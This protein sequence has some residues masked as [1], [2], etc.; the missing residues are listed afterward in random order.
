MG[1][2]WEFEAN[3]GECWRADFFL[4][5][6]VLHDVLDMLHVCIWGLSACLLRLQ[7]IAATTNWQL[8]DMPAHSCNPW[9]S[10]VVDPLMCQGMAWFTRDIDIQ[11]ING[12]SCDS[13][14]GERWPNAWNQLCGSQTD[15]FE[16]V[17]YS[18]IVTS[19]LH[20]YF[21]QHLCLPITTLV[22]LC[23]S[24][25]ESLD[26]VREHRRHLRELINRVIGIIMH[27]TRDL[28]VAAHE[29]ILEKTPS[30]ISNSQPTLMASKNA[31]CL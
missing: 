14:H 15:L 29:S 21:M 27:M 25:A 13:M 12:G 8:N 31:F 28:V 24:D 1:V 10:V 17:R 11:R 4:V 3:V 22:R 23:P 18:S 26:S 2:H 5:T 20:V 7:R 19:V 6:M 16:L 30:L 9:Q